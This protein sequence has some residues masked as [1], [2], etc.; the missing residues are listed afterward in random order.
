MSEKILIIGKNSKIAKEFV[1]K[2]GNKSNIIQPSKKEWDMNSLSF[3]NEQNNL[4]K[5]SNRILLL[6]S[7]ISNKK[8]IEREEI[9]IV[10]Q[11]KI[12]LLSTIKICEIA[13]KYNKNVKIIVLGSESGIKGSYDIVYALTKSSIHKYI[14]EKKIKHPNQQLLC[15][16]P[17]TIV[18]AGIT[19]RRKD[20]NNVDKSIN[21]NPKKRGIKSREIANLIYSLF[22]DQS[23]YINNIVI[24]FDGGKFARMKT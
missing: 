15:I 13:I 1:K 20:Q 2:V 6:H 9:D 14:K 18:D 11:I 12:N 10:K 23:N 4:I 24:G 8:F 17:S 16:A 22:F 3:T 7:V 19:L 21:D 5:K